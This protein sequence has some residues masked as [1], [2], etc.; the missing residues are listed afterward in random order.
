MSSRAEEKG[1]RRAE[2]EA[3]ERE[4]A[5]R[6]KRARIARTG[7]A[8][9][10]TIALVAGIVAL[11][12]TAGG[13][14]RDPQPAAA[15]PTNVALPPRGEED[16]TAAVEK[17][18]AT[19]RELPSL[20]GAHRDGS[21]ALSEY[22]SNPPT[23]GPHNPVPAE[24]GVYEPGNG[25]AHENWVH[26]LEHGAIVFLYAPGTAEKRIRQLEALAAEPVAG[27]PGGYATLVLENKTNMPYQVA[28]V[29]W[30]RLLGDEQ[31]T[32]ASFDALRAF[33]EEFINQ[34]PEQVAW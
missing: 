30:T 27:Y 24:P 25:P 3:A 12:L 8:G 20:G 11:A 9:A 22:N 4:A 6:A 2:R 34:G 14:T 7:G 18:A 13:G 23:S 19:F 28:A 5:K 17:A 31:L 15:A 21:I 16:L 29:A 10:V 26:S 32:D 33:R 1:R